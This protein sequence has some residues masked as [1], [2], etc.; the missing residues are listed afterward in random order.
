MKNQTFCY[1][2]QGYFEIESEP[3]LEK[4]QVLSIQEQLL[5]ISEPFGSFTSWLNDVCAYIKDQQYRKET[6]DYFLPIIRFNLNG[7]FEHVID[8]SYESDKS[9]AELQDIHDGIVL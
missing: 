1:W 6:M 8:L 5:K 4:R 7:I 9:Q 2:L 3:V